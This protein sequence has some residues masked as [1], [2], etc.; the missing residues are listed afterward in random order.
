MGRDVNSRTDGNGCNVPQIFDGK[1]KYLNDNGLEDDL[2]HKF[3]GNQHFGA[4]PGDYTAYGITAK[5]ESVNNKVTFD[6]IKEQLEKC[7]D[8]EVGI[9]WNGRGG[10]LVR[11]YGCGETLGKPY[12]R[13]AHDKTQ[14]YA[15]SGGTILGDN[16]GLETA[17]VYVE[18]LDNDGMMNWGSRDDEIVFAMSESPRRLTVTDIYTQIGV[19]IVVTNEGDETE[20]I[21]WTIDVECPMIMFGGSNEGTDE[22]AAGE[23]MTINSGFFFGLGKGS[24]K[25][26]LNE[27]E[28]NWD[29]FILGPFAMMIQ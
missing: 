26:M 4:I 9:K 12:L 3:Q 8:V 1:F 18:D 2:V 17:Q 7:E 21:D 15:G 11:I 28:H 6:W 10:H 19:Y 22:I 25:F 23:E 13:Y 24:I 29:C 14:A 5:D 16:V 20:L 27:E